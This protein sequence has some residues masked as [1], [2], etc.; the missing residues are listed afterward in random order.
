[1]GS[2]DFLYM[3]LIAL[4]F[5]VTDLLWIIQISSFLGIFFT[6]SLRQK[7]PQIPFIPYLLLGILSYLPIASFVF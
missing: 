4:V 7:S 3:A 6:V 2:G 1:M 5:S